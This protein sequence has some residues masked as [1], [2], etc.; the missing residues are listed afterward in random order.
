[1]TTRAVAKE[2]VANPIAR[3]VEKRI[4]LESK[5]NGEKGIQEIESSEIV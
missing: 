1:L 4:V 5:R 2:A 3:I